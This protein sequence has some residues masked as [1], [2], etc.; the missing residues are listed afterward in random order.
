[1]NE[2]SIFERIIEGTIPSEKVFE[3]ERIIAIKDIHPAAP[4]HL[5]II[6]KKKIPVRLSHRS[7]ALQLLQRMRDEAHR[8]AVTYHR[9]LR[10]EKMLGLCK[11][12]RKS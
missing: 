7:L 5:L 6:P 1:M 11:A 8:F 3:N 2:K 9:H 12:N 4:V 10:N